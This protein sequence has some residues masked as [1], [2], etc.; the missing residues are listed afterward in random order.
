[1][2]TPI[3]LL[4]LAAFACSTLAADVT[5]TWKAQV[6]TQIGLQKYTFT[7]RQ[8]GAKVTG[9]ANAEVNGEKRETE[10]K[11]G[12]LDGDT[13]SFVELL[14]F[15]GNELHI[16]YKGILLKLPLTITGP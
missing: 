14:N 4:T 15:Q 2:R 12:K 5:G 7:L 3:T 13:I 11:E 6:D 16:G 1:M 8:D 10:L 9:K